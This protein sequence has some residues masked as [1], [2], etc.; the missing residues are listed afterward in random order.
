VDKLTILEIGA[1]QVGCPGEIRSS[2]WTHP[3]SEMLCF[4]S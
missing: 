4:S 3:G 2:P 1:Y